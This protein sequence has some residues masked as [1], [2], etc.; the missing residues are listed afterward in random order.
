MPTVLKVGRFRFFFF[1][2]EWDEPIHIHI[3]SGDEYAKFWLEPVQ[4]AKS[5]GYNA[6]ELKMRR[7]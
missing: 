1:S 3:E 6:K 5:V 7:N 4:L 2:N